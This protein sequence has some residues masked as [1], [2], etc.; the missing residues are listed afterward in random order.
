MSAAHDIDPERRALGEKTYKA[1]YGADMFTLPAGESDYFDIMMADLFGGVWSRPGLEIGLRRLL[2]IGVLA[3]QQRFD[4]M[5]LQFRRA[6]RL[7]ELD[8]EGV[9]EAVIHLIPYVGYPSG[10]GLWKAGEAAIAHHLKMGLPM[11]R[12]RPPGS[13]NDEPERARS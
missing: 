10:G 2:V 9:R 12:E 6:L 4:A 7:G 5:E 13:S 1:V 8:A 3:T 11:A